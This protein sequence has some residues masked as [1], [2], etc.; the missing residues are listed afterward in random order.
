MIC[1]LILLRWR[2]RRRRVCDE[3][4]LHQG[5]RDEPKVGL[6]TH[7]QRAAS[8]DGAVR[9]SECAATPAPIAVAHTHHFATT[10]ARSTIPAVTSISTS[11][12]ASRSHGSTTGGSSCCFLRHCYRLL[13]HSSAAA[14]SPEKQSLASGECHVCACHCQRQMRQRRDVPRIANRLRDDIG[15][16]PHCLN[17]RLQCD[18]FQ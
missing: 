12:A 7:G 8:L 2:L 4:G 17:I 3:D 1:L 9:A 15:S 11:F 10:A 13:L 6:H 16:R 5:R 18:C 14:L